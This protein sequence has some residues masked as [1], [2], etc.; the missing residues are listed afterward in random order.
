[1]ILVNAAS[2]GDE[3]IADGYAIP[4]VHITYDE[5]VTLKNW[6]ATG[7]GHT[8]AILGTVKDIQP[9]NGDVMAAFSSRGQNNQVPD[10]IKPDMTA[11]GVDIMAAWGTDP[12][13]PAPEYNIISGTSM[14][15]P[16][17]AGA[18]ALMMKAKYPAWSVAEIQSAMMTTSVW[19]N[20]LRKEDGATPTDPFDRGCGPG[21][22]HQ[23]SERGLAAQ[24]HQRRVQRGEP[25]DRRAIPR[26]STTRPWA[27]TR[28]TSRA[29]GRERCATRP[30]RP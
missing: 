23:C 8:G 7:T 6:L 21:Q 22:H 13:F 4:G 9:N 16:H 28:A 10:L 2:N 11:P 18:G 20:S 29:A 30:A 1:M 26:R 3:E 19:D 15:S 5:G 12:L 27:T 24:H 25:G 14:S 17:M